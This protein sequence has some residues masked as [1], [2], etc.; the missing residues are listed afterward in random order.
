[1][2][3]VDALAVRRSGLAAGRSVQ[4]TALAMRRAHPFGQFGQPNDASS[5]N[6]ATGCNDTVFQFLVLLIQGRWLT[7]DWIRA[8]IGHR[9]PLRG[10]TYGEASAFV[11]ALNLG[12]RVTL[13]L[14]PDQILSFV[15]ARGPVMVGE[16]YPD[17]P[18]WQG[19]RYR[20]RTATGRRNGFSWPR[21]K[22]GATQL[23]S[24][25]FRHAVL[26][27]GIAPIPA[28]GGQLGCYV[29][30]PN[31]NSPARPEDVAYDILTLTQVRTL[32]DRYGA[33]NGGSYAIHPT[34]VVK[35][36]A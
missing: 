4:S 13:R 25:Y 29:M 1:M 5:N 7:H 3:L 28:W 8:K 21:R 11:Q 14:S 34:R 18:E 23:G 27:I 6:G 15:R 30:E 24:T 9:N 32:I 31:H 36:A 16:M 33:T 19:Y 2:P 10:L 20:G 26:L 35:I 17:H 12:Y 22:S